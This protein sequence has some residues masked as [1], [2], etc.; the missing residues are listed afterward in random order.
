MRFIENHDEPRAA[1]T[2][3]VRQGASRGRRDAQ[4]DRARGSSTTASSTGGKRAPAGVPRPLAGR[5]ARRRDLR[6]VLRA[7]ARRR[8]RD[9]RLPHGR[10]QLGE[11][12]GWDGN[13][14]WQNLVAWGWRDDA[15]QARRREPRRRTRPPATSRCRGTTS[16][17]STWRLVDAAIGDDVT[18]AAATTCATGCTSRC[19]PWGWHLFDLT[20]SSDGELTARRPRRPPSMRASPRPPAAPRTTSS[21]PTRGTSGART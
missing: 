8:S 18:S 20:P 7:A 6:G 16:A 15:P 10:W 14:S 9:P 13:D 21:T 2:F 19:E 11:R 12:S 17:A 1:A 5:G 3:R 4:P